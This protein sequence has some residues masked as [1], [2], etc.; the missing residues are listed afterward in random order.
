VKH[1]G[2]AA[3]DSI[4]LLLAELRRIEGVRERKRGVFYRKSAA[5]IHFH[6]DPAGIFADLR[7]PD[8][9]IRLPVNP[10]PERDQSSAALP[11]SA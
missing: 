3:L 10:P 2:E 11:A 7:G 4:E 6:E 8:G 9:W 5:F 1:A